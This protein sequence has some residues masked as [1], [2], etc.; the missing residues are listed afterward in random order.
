MDNYIY[1]SVEEALE[2]LEDR[3]EMYQLEAH[4]IN[5][6]STIKYEIFD[7]D[8]FYTMIL[9]DQIIDFEDLGNP[10]FYIDHCYTVLYG[11]FDDNGILRLQTHP[12]YFDILFLIDVVKACDQNSDIAFKWTIA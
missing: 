1:F 7:G 8:D 6:V 11:N 3:L 10:V 2:E 4:P 12:E 9:R 5:D